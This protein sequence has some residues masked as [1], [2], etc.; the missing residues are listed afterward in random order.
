MNEYVYVSVILKLHRVSKKSHLWLA[1]ILTY[2]IRLRSFLAELLLKNQ[3]ITRCFVF[4]PY[5]SG[6]LTLPC[7]TGNPENSTLVL[8]ACNTVEL[9]RR[10]RLPFSWPPP[11]KTPSWTHWLQDLESHAAAWIW[12]MS[13]KS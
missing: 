13:Q 4:P 7:E 8:C 5:L 1:I 2:M 9:L 12:V 10:S 11:P 6:A 3:D